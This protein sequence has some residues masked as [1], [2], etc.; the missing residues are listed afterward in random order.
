MAIDE[1]LEKLT[2]RHKALTQTIERIATMQRDLTESVRQDGEHIR[3]LA[4]IAETHER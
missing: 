3:A 4:R 2:E 1:R